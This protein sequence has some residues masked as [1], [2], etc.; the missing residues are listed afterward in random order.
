MAA[1]PK[2][3]V[4]ISG[5]ARG[6]DGWAEAAARA[7]GLEVEIYE[8]DW[9]NLGPKA[10]PIRNQQIV[11][12]S[13]E[14]VAFWDGKSRGTLNTLLLTQEASLPVT[15]FDPDG[16]RVP[17]QHATKTAK[18]IGV[19]ASLEKGRAKLTKNQ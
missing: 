12:R 3:T 4:V 16:S 14:V 19:M 6:V 5:G 2:G 8:A 7:R 17:L 15:I 10:G 1:L 13:N 9:K 18:E 11:S